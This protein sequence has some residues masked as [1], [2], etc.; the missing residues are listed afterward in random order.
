MLGA[1]EEY[2]EWKYYSY[3]VAYKEYHRFDGLTFYYNDAAAEN[4]S[5]TI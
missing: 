3:M 2:E 1:G 5:D 4:D